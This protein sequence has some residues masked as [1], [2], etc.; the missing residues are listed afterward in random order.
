M[1]NQNFFWG[2]IIMSILSSPVLLLA[3]PNDCSLPSAF[4]YLHANDIRARINNGGSLFFKES[5]DAGFQVPYQPSPESPAT[6]FISGLWMGG[7]D[8]VG[9]LKLSAD[10]YGV[11]SGQSSY[12]AGPLDP[13]TGT[14]TFDD[15]NDWDRIFT[16]R[17]Y[18]LLAHLD[19]WNDNGQIDNPIPALLTW[20]GNNN[21][22]FEN[23][24]GVALP[25]NGPEGLAPFFDWN[26]DG[27]YDPF[28]GDYP[29]PQGVDA[30]PEQ[31][32]WWVF[33]DNGNQVNP[34]GPL[35]MEVQVTVWGFSCTD[36]ELLDQTVF[37]SHKLISRSQEPLDS[38]YVAMFTDF[39]LGCYTD[40]YIGA[41][42]SSNSY[43]V[44]NQD[45]VDGDVGTDCLGGAIPYTQEPPA[46]SV[47]FLN[48]E[49][50]S[51]IYFNNGSVGNPT[52]P[53]TDPN[54]G[55]EF[56]RLMTGRWRD[57][58]PLTEGGDGYD[59]LGVPTSYAFPDD[60]NDV[61]GWSM[62]NE[63]F[64]NS[65]DQRAV[66]SVE[67]GLFQPGQIFTIDIAWSFHRESGNDHL[68]NVSLMYSEV[69]EIQD[70]YDQGF[71]GLCTPLTEVCQSDCV[72]PGDLNADGIANYCDLLA[73]KPGLGTDGTTRGGPLN[74]AP[75]SSD[76][77]IE[78]LPSNVNYK[79][80]DADGNGLINSV[81]LILTENHYG[82][83]TPWYEAPEDEFPEGPEIVAA[84]AFTT[85]SFEDIENGQTVYVEIQLT[86]DIPDLAGFAF[87]LAIDTSYFKDIS[88][89]P[90]LNCMVNDCLPI[91]NPVG[92]YPNS[93]QLDYAVVIEEP[94]LSLPA[95]DYFL[96]RL[97]AKDAFPNPLPTD[98]TQLLIKNI[99][100]I[101]SDGTE[102]EMGA[103][104]PVF[105]F[106]GVTVISSTKE[107]QAGAF[108]MIP[109][110]ASEHVL[111]QF[112][113][114]KERSWTLM[115]VRG[116][117]LYSNQCDFCQSTIMPLNDLPA[118]MYFVQV[119]EEGRMR[120][121]K[122]VI[123][124]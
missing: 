25:D 13:A 4:D 87:Q 63:N 47:T 101:A 124:R 82:L 22:H 115:D 28:D 2:W 1:K 98:S 56:Y 29:L 46:Q 79:H 58:Q 6:M 32:S 83:T 52:P 35:K 57:G 41:N 18:E 114:E 5:G 61:D 26:N 105:T 42:P 38:V 80:I 16:V 72:W 53:T 104:L 107:V 75:R 84:P 14:T 10:T 44:Y 89:F 54:T 71:D 85:N 31:I 95:G 120:T 36:N 78:S 81:D 111:I 122:L 50:S 93:D 67:V 7:F 3:Q 96:L 9:N 100:A 74:W 40:D 99:K 108:Q 51:F 17:G 102:I 37:T 59:P 88:F 103:T 15:C 11:F 116:Q 39:D 69:S 76:N 112:D 66:G 43:F 55:I 27:M 30:I 86:E 49:L 21:P 121:E 23:L 110:P 33:N 34:T 19:D 90:A 113:R 62:F 70:Q 12:T 64:S 60:P 119:I 68:Q 123:E 106:E 118:G 65:F 97:R 73:L 20:P 77:W 91:S 48:Q 45:N 92:Y 117:L 94:S 8:P 109:N 24:T